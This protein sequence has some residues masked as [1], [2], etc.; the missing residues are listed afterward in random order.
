MAIPL[1][2]RLVVGLTF[3]YFARTNLTS[4]KVSKM[5]LLEHSNFTSSRV[6]LYVLVLIEFVSGLALIIGIGT[7]I[8]SLVVSVLLLIGVGVKKKNAEALPYS[9]GFLTLLLLVTT[10]LLFLGPGFYAIDFPF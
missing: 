10:S 2:F 9:S 8:A 7:Q 4:Q 1:V 3:V 5:A 6:W